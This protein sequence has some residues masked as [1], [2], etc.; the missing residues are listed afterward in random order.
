MGEAEKGLHA[1][2]KLFEADR[3]V[4]DKKMRVWSRQTHRGRPP[5]MIYES[6]H[7][8]LLASHYPLMSLDAVKNLFNSWSKRF[9]LFRAQFDESKATTQAIIR[10]RALAVDQAL[11]TGWL[12]V[13]NWRVY[14]QEDFK[15]IVQRAESL[16]ELD[17]FKSSPV[18]AFDGALYLT[19]QSHVSRVWI[20]IPSGGRFDCSAPSGGGKECGIAMRWLTYSK[21]Q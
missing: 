11:W 10:T 20:P 1:V 4:I 2:T 21:Q 9:D 14:R 12:R 16:V 3:T 13:T 5:Q 18:F 8:A 19:W 15:E 17:A 6:S 7:A